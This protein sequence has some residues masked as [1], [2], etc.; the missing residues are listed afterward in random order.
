MQTTQYTYLHVFLVISTEHNKNN[1]SKLKTDGSN[2]MYGV[3]D[4][5]AKNS[6]WAKCFRSCVRTMMKPKEWLGNET[7]IIHRF[8]CRV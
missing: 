4:V 3:D 6:S 2:K 8:D 1:N 7:F 5:L